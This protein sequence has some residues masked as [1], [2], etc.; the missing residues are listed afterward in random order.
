MNGQTELNT[1][2]RTDLYVKSGPEP[3]FYK[4]GRK[5][6]VGYSLVDFAMNLV[7]QTIMMFLTFFYTDVFNL[8]ATHIAMIFLLARIWDAI[9]DPSMGIIVERLNLKRGKYK[10]YIL[11]GAIPFGIMAILTYTVPTSFSYSGK[12]IWAFLTY[13]GLN[14]IYCFI[15]Q[16]YISLTTVMSADPNERT[17]LNSIRMMFAQS[18]G[19]VVALS[20]PILT[21]YFGGGNII[22]GYQI[23]V[24]LLSVIMVGILIYSYTTFIERIKVNSH[25][26][27]VRLKDVLFQMTHNKPGVI[28]FFLFVGVYGFSVIQSASGIYYMTYFA[29]RPDLVAMFSLMNVLPS[30]IGVP[31]VPM[32]V[33]K[34]KKKNTVLLGLF[35]AGI[36]AGLLWVVPTTAI[37]M[38]MLTRGIASFGY[39]ILMGI[40]WSIIPDAVEYAEYNTGKRYTAVVYTTITLGL[41]ASFTIGGVIPTIILNN[42][43]YVPNQVQTLEALTGIRFMSSLIPCIV[44]LATIVIFGMFYNLTEEKVSEIMHILA[45]RNGTIEG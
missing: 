17:K 39:G 33:R 45:V 19:V 40:L 30:V 16:P 36:G 42:V 7:F 25:L 11:Y 20:I 2:S 31:F 18:G 32:L 5:E 9:C 1:K 26:N 23:T 43:N 21:H 8:K 27:P 22:R 24:A 15:I 6:I 29:G 13:N 38:M 44:C 34:I 35:I 10:P 3:G 41:K 28:L 12:L 4:L 37:S 14:M